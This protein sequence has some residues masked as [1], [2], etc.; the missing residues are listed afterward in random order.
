[1]RPYAPSERGD[2]RASRSLVASCRVAPKDAAI[3]AQR[4]MGAAATAR[5]PARVRARLSHWSPMVASDRRVRPYAPSERYVQRARLPRWSR[6]AASPPRMR[7]L[8]PIEQ[9][10]PPRLRL[11]ARPARLR[12]RPVRW[13][14]LAASHWRMRPLPPSERWVPPAPAPALPSRSLV[15]SGRVTPKDAAAQAH[16]SSRA[17]R[18]TA[19]SRDAPAPRARGGRHCAAPARCHA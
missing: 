4:A 17:A 6:L 11:R 15:A 12:A 14:L 16:R 18:L 2:L 1:M 13:S 10:V 7:P 3:R 5:R 8:P 9:W 19:A